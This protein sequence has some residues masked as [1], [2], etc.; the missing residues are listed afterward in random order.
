MAET[1]GE[2]LNDSNSVRVS[3]TRLSSEPRRETRRATEESDWLGSVTQWPRPRLA[4]QS[5]IG[6]D[7]SGRKFGYRTR[8][9]TPTRSPCQ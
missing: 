7:T 8:Y 4:A 6:S 9:S 3:R 2:V 5:G 1:I